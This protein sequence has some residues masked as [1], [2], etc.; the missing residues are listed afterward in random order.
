MEHQAVRTD[1]HGELFSDN[2]DFQ[3]IADDKAKFSVRVK[4]RSCHHMINRN[5]G[6]IASTLVNYFG[7]KVLLLHF[8]NGF[9]PQRLSHFL[10]I[11][12]SI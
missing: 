5:S 3:K 11:I 1:I 9:H 7:G 6:V 2:S 4:T 12:S 8:L 10:A